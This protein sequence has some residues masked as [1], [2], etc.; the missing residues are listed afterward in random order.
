MET[1][2]H[3]LEVLFDGVGGGLFLLLLGNFLQKRQSASESSGE[4]KSTRKRLLIRV[5]LGVAASCLIVGIIVRELPTR[6]VQ[7]PP[8]FDHPTASPGT[9]PP[10]AGST[11][12]KQ[13]ASTSGKPTTEA[14]PAKR[15]ATVAERVTA[16]IANQLQV[17]GSNVKPEDDFEMD[18]GAQPLDVTELVMRLETEYKITIPDKDAKRL[19]TVKDTIDY[20]AKRVCSGEPKNVDCQS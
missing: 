8:T 9:A 3:W 4:E 7:V 18:L 19:K 6:N 11:P 2:K 20:I 13:A 17:S 14:E 1:T 16:I 10:Q 12:E 15:R 5:G